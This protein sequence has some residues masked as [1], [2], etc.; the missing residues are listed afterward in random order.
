MVR[1]LRPMMALT[2]APMHKHN[3]TDPNRRRQRMRPVVIHKD[4]FGH[5]GAWRQPS[6][7]M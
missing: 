5:V 7:S 1:Q 4:L 3:G 6:H 2:C